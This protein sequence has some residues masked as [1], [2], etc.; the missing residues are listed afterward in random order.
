MCS[1]RYNKYGDNINGDH[2]TNIKSQ[3]IYIVPFLCKG[4]YFV[5][6][7]L[8]SKRQVKLNFL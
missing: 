5:D 8:I 6:N 4:L 7:N 1:K 3:K 2:I